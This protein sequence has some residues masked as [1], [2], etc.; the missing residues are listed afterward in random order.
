MS[1]T[2]WG[3]PWQCLTPHKPQ[4][5]QETYQI[6]GY[7]YGRTTPPLLF[8]C[9]PIS[10]DP[11][12]R[13]VASS[14]HSA[15][16]KIVRPSLISTEVRTLLYEEMP[17]DMSSN[18]HTRVAPGD[19]CGIRRKSVPHGFS[20]GRAIIPFSGSFGP[21]FA[22]VPDDLPVAADPGLRP[23]HVSS[24]VW[25]GMRRSVPRAPGDDPEETRRDPG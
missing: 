14:V 19:G 5:Y 1:G 22:G 10:P 6:H 23:P 15:F 11:R 4:N 24:A 12:D 13:P 7:R 18:G 8:S 21:V 20:G 3:H 16:P 2:G 17:A 9:R 25:R